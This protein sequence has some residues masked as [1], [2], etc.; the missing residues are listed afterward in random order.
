M[1]RMDTLPLYRQ[2]AN[3]YRHAI[4]AGTLAAGERLPSVR[5]MMQRHGV[6]LTTA[7]QA[8]RQLEADGVV[9]ARPRSG[10]FVRSRRSGALAP[11]SE[12]VSGLPD[13]AQYIGI[14][15]RVSHIIAAGQQAQVNVN[16]SGAAGAPAL[17]PTAALHSASINAL[18]KLHD[19]EGVYGQPAPPS[20]H[21]ALRDILAKRALAAGITIS[22]DDIII[23]HGCIEA[24]NL[25]LRAVSQPGDVVAVES[26]TFFGLLQ[27]LESLGLRAVEIP[28][29]PS[30]G[31][32]LEAL[33]LAAQ[34]YA[35][36]RAV[37]VV[38]NLQNPLGCIMPD[39][40]KAALVAWCEQQDIAL[41]EDDTYSV[42]ADSE[43][44]PT[45]L[46]SWD[47]SGN[48]IHCASLHKTLAPGLRLGWIS[49]GRW[50]ARVAMLKYAQSRG[51]ELLPQ[52]AVSDFMAS[53]AYE[54]HLRRLRTALQHQ[55][56]QMADAIASYFPAG[57]RLN[58]P[59]GGVAL[60]V[61][62]PE[63]A[64]SERLFHQAL[65]EGI[66]I[67]PGLMYSNS[68]RF[69]R[70]IRLCFG[71]PYSREMDHAL[72]RLATLALSV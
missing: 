62:L 24:L 10:Y 65:H 5:V 58:V 41:I 32:S 47:R 60:W 29:S 17:Y 26:P 57:T 3:H 8:C 31:L 19:V 42:L 27:I 23:T 18:R 59:A 37:V 9:E 28:A 50:Q 71:A 39:S 33:Q 56:G 49:A 54:R 13:P 21:P 72:R 64:S 63:G 66:R 22:Q 51:N 12:P 43:V 44:Q 30:T 67:S 35:G 45:A 40:Q 55:R 20:G 61:E 52:L 46:K 4:A 11:A 48:V 6:S 68:R 34:T 25:A 70:H 2:L 1:P 16:L 36:I 53:G 7:L 69:D 14:H 15:P 38:P